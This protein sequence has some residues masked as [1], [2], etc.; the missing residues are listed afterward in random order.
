[1]LITLEEYA[2][3]HGVA[4]ETV[5]RKLA[6]KKY[7]TGKRI[8]KQWYLDSEDV[9]PDMRTR[10]AKSSRKSTQP[11]LNK[12]RTKDLYDKETWDMLTEKD[13]CQ[14]LLWEQAMEYS[15]LQ[16]D[17]SAC[18]AIFERFPVDAFDRYTAKELGEIAKMIY[19]AYKDGAEHERL[20]PS[21]N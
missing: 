6:S 20:Y 4:S 10:E 9:L 8:G 17:P 2:E 12:F 14:I 19:K 13:R 5:R 11:S 21:E 3:L 18:K 15:G 7:K 1:M 16:E